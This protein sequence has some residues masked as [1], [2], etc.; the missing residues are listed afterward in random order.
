[1]PGA[2]TAD[3]SARVGSSHGGPEPVPPGRRRHVP[4][5]VELRAGIIVG[6]ST[7][8]L[9]R[10]VAYQ[11]G[12]HDR[13]RDRV[14]AFAELGLAGPS[15]RQRR[16]GA[17]AARAV[18][19]RH[20]ERRGRDALRQRT[21][22]WP[23]RRW[24]P[25]PWLVGWSPPRMPS[26]RPRPPARPPR[27][28]DG[29]RSA[30]ARQATGSGLRDGHAR[31]RGGQAARHGV[32]RAAPASQPQ[33]L[34]AALEAALASRLAVRPAVAVVA[35]ADGAEATG[36]AWARPSD[37]TARSAST[38][39]MPPASPGGRAADDGAQRGEGRAGTHACGAGGA[40]SPAGLAR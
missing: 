24:W 32:R 14:H 34:T 35:R 12:A 26:V 10:Q 38:P 20:R 21:S 19:E 28:R 31:G 39:A 15:S 29:P 2:P 5:A 7:P 37:A 6:F 17:H 22:C 4:L 36:R 18:W 30:V 40:T 16:P 3:V 13:R 8:V 33:T 1:M 23:R 9:A 11:E 27:S 25:C